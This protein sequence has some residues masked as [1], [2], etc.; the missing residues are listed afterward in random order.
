MR[1]YGSDA[2]R[3][4]AFVGHGGSGKTTL[5]DTIR[6]SRI[7]AGESLSDKPAFVIGIILAAAYLLY[8]IQRVLLGKDGWLFFADERSVESHR[9]V[10]PFSAVELAQWRHMVDLWVAACRGM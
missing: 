10:Q 7:A 1:V 2:I 3:N 5:I 6:K 4:V 9:R 8:M